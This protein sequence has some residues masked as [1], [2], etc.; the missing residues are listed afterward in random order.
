MMPTYVSCVHR[1]PTERLYALDDRTF[2]RHGARGYWV[3]EGDGNGAVSRL[4]YWRDN[5][6]IVWQRT[7]AH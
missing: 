5:N 7:R 3:F 2:I 4:V 6:A 1:A